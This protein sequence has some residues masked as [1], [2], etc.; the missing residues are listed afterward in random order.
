MTTKIRLRF[1][2]HIL[3]YR[4]LFAALLISGLVLPTI[5]LAYPQVSI[6]LVGA[7]P[8]A[9]MHNSTTPQPNSLFLHR[10][11]A[12]FPV[13]Q[14]VEGGNTE[15][16]YRHVY[17]GISLAHFVNEHHIEFAFAL[18]QGADPSLIRFMI[19][20]VDPEA[21]TPDGHMIYQSEGLE[22]YQHAPVVR[23]KEAN[24]STRVLTAQYTM[25]GGTETS[26]SSPALNQVDADKYNETLF[27]IIPGDI[28]TKGPDYDFYMARFEMTNRQWVRFLNDAEQNPNNARGENLFFDKQGNVWFHPDKRAGRDEIFRIDADVILYTPDRVRG[29]R[30]RLFSD[31]QGNTPYANHPVTGVS[32]FGALKY[33]NWLTIHTGRGL[34]QRAYSEGTNQQDWAPITATN[35]H[36]G[37]FSFRERRDWINV[38]GFRLP[39]FEFTDIS[40]QYPTNTFN[41]F[42]K[43]ASWNG[44]TNTL[45]GFGRNTFTTNDAIVLDS[46]LRHDIELKPVGFFDGMNRLSIGRTLRNE[47]GFGIHDLTGSVGEWLNDFP[48]HGLPDMRLVA[49]GSFKEPIRPIHEASKMAPS[50]SSSAGGFRPI[51]TYMPESITFINV[52]FCFHTTND[53]PHALREKYMIPAPGEPLDPIAESPGFIPDPEVV[54]PEVGIEAPP[55]VDPIPDDLIEASDLPDMFGVSISGIDP[56]DITPPDVTPP[57]VSAVRLT[58]LSEGPDG[59][60]NTRIEASSDLNGN[61]VGTTTFQRFY[62]IGGMTTLVAPLTSNGNVFSHW[63]I[64]GVSQGSSPTITLTMLTDTTIIAVYISPSPSPSGL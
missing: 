21:V 30:Y 48:H 53:I 61:A 38:Q 58:V 9:E 47:N 27:N 2:L 34:G 51:T 4:E 41:E 45:Y 25:L 31:E 62:T 20:G 64:G 63:R 32:W 26:I 57:P 24:G 42:Y 19:E 15:P 12:D 10:G 17:P 18:I 37:E 35:W 46:V 40:S 13:A 5:A 7:A 23:R 50:A 11:H 29:D 52:I 3:F 56:V 22:V 8:N 1:F 36:N 60:M 16:V 59:V 54:W 44:Q 14:D 33:C 6:H 43:A 39:M 49:G 28:G 55:D